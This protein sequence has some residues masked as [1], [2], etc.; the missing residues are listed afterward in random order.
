MSA[1]CCFPHKSLI[2]EDHNLMTN[3]C[4]KYENCFTILLIFQLSMYLLP[5]LHFASLQFKHK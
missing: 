2:R 1:L 5:V 4:K 3:N